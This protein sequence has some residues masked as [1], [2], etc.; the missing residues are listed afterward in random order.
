[1]LF[2]ARIQGTIG[3]YSGESNIEYSSLLDRGSW[4]HLNKDFF[5]YHSTVKEPENYIRQK[6]EAK[7]IHFYGEISHFLTANMTSY[8]MIL[9]TMKV[10]V[11]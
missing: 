2:R 7:I 5:H 9:E 8:M 3:M 6:L 10:G 4:C 11:L 1:M